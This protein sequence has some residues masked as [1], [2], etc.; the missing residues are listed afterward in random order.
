MD[1]LNKFSKII[2]SL[3]NRILFHLIYFVGFGVTSLISKLM[4]KRFLDSFPKD[5]TW[6][7]PTGSSNLNKMF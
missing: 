7:K 1:I 3:V 5:S 4:G 6:R 2:Q